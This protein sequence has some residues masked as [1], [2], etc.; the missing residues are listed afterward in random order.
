[1]CAESKKAADILFYQKISGMP[2]YPYL[3]GDD[4]VDVLKKKH[5]AGAYESLVRPFNFCS[6]VLCCLKQWFELYE[7]LFSFCRFFILKHV[8]PEASLRA[9]CRMTSIS[10]RPPHQMQRRAAG[11]R[12]A[13][14]SFRNP[15]QNMIP[16]WATCIVLLGWKT[17][18]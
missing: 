5:A 15:H 18:T 10:T 8:N 9:C 2:T 12:T 6:L 14:A 1:M 16:A 13:P 11:E 4:L 17:G 3:Y 7:C